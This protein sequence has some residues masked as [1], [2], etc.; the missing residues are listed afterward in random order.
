MSKLYI[1]TENAKY[2]VFNYVFEKKVKLNPGPNKIVLLS[3][4]IG[5]QVI[6]LQL[7]LL[8][9]IYFNSLGSNNKSC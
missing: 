7:V 5:L 4:T 1:G 3:A 6:N 8:H 9:R 2:G